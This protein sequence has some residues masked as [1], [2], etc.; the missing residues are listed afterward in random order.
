MRTSRFI[1]QKQNGKMAAASR[2][3]FVEQWKELPDGEYTITIEEGKRG[4]TSTRYKYY[5]DCVLFEIMRQAGRFFRVLNHN[6]GEQRQP[7]NVNELHEIMK[8]LYNPITVQVNGVTML[9]P[10]TTTELTDREFI[11]HFM[12][13]IISDHSG[14]PYLVEVPMYED[15]VELRKKNKYK[16]ISHQ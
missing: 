11:G 14:P 2:E 9:I 3:I 13:Q 8:A 15:W 5:F 12:E 10:G 7:A 4:Y 1:I 16:I 6:T